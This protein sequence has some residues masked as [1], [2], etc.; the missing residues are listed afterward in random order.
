MS[1][2]AGMSNGLQAAM[3]LARGRADGMA[4]LT[5]RDE[6]AL[7]TAARSFWAA[8]L[9]LPAFIC[10]QLI[11]LAQAP[12]PAPA[13][14]AHGF[15]LQL[16]GYAIDWP[17]YALISRAIA[18]GM[19]RRDAWPRFIAAWNWCN[20]V[21]YLLLVAASLPPLLGLPDIAGET[22]WLAASGWA[23]WI[24]WYATRLALNVTGMQAAGFVA[25][26]EAMGITLLAVIQAIGGAG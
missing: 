22:A 26:D 13:H 10:L 19:G 21:Q 15:A 24:E 3:L 8:A 5:A 20:V 17:A 1:T 25:L 6:P 9:C 4:V 14:A 12:S 18:I 11:D 7:A 2:L 23:L 16:L